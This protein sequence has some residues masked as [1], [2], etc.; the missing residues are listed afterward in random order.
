MDH[1]HDSVSLESELR[2]RRTTLRDDTVAS[3]RWPHP[4]FLLL[5][6]TRIGGSAFQLRSRTAPHRR[7]AR[8]PARDRCHH[9]SRR[10]YSPAAL[11]PGTSPHPAWRR[12]TTAATG[13]QALRLRGARGIMDA[14][15][16]PPPLVGGATA[17]DLAA[18]LSRR[19]VALAAPPGAADE[20]EAAEASPGESSPFYERAIVSNEVVSLRRKHLLALTLSYHVS[21]VQ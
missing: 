6:G 9:P 11:T 13:T 3:M 7:P 5:R 15:G 19:C 8:H 21:P 1:H 14:T 20:A 4:C 17:A 12:T 10:R 16:P 18:D 2:N